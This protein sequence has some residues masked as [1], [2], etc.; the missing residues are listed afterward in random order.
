MMKK[1]STGIV[2][3]VHILSCNEE[4][5]ECSFLTCNFHPLFHLTMQCVK[6]VKPAD[7]FVNRR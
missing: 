1:Y 2:K 4:C 3:G 5:R 7:R 6:H